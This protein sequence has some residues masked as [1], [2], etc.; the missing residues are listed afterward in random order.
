MELQK[1]KQQFDQLVIITTKEVEKIEAKLGQELP[2]Y[3][4][5]STE[6][7]LTG[8]S[9]LRE[10]KTLND[11]EK[12]AILKD[13]IDGLETKL[14]HSKEFLCAVNRKDDNAIEVLDLFN[15]IERD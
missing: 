13:K 1:L 7:D 15:E 9:V 2:A 4:K 6:L 5:L 3:K 11:S 10:Y 8:F 14:I 12:Q